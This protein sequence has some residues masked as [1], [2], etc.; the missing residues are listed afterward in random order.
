[1]PNQPRQKCTSKKRVDPI[2]EFSHDYFL[3]V[4]HFVLRPNSSDWFNIEAI[5][6]NGKSNWI[7]IIHINLTSI[8]KNQVGIKL[9]TKPVL[10]LVN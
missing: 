5:P 10:K 7:H 4:H 9:A 2:K 8:F 3:H 1:M 6:A